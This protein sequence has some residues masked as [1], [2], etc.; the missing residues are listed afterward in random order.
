MLYVLIAVCA[1]LFVLCIRLIIHIFALKREM[2]R[3]KEEL[4][5]T[6]QMSYNR[7]LTISILDKDLSEMAAEMNRNLDYQKQLKYETER[8]ERNLKQS[9]SDIAHDLRTPLTVIKG[10][11][12]MLE[13]EEQLS[14]R[15]IDYLR[16]CMEKSDAMKAMA[17][18]F[19]ELSVLES[20]RSEPAMT[21]VNVTNSLM[22]FIADNEAVIR[23]NNLTPDIVFPEK[24]VFIT[25]DEAMLMRIL[26]NLL[27]NV[28]KY[29][30]GS[31]GIELRSDEKCTITFSN[32]VDPSRQFDTEHLFDRTYRGDKARQG[33]GAGL[34]LYI[35]KLLAEK[36]GAEVKAARKNNEL[37]IS[38][39]FSIQ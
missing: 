7:Q 11:L 30:H 13:R 21:R 9:V 15:G 28:I 17:D 22:Q 5:L 23:T 18:D 2:R 27:N 31:F 29:A 10:N 16:V 12:Q 3:V 34:G 8:G 4:P 36:Q 39:I 25:A 1:A 6:K 24:S 20:D 14:P 37:C 33:G 35:V 32:A 38:V 19:F 26:G